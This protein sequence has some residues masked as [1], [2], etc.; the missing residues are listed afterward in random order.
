[1][2]HTLPL[3]VVLAL[4][5][6]D[7]PCG[8]SD[9]QRFGALPPTACH[10]DLVEPCALVPDQIDRAFGASHVGVEDR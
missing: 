2:E 1:M 4:N 10:A 7:Q 8:L 9:F 6:F 5:L 3:L